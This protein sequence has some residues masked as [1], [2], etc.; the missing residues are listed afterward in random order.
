MLLSQAYVLLAVGQGHVG[1]IYDYGLTGF[2]AKVE[3]QTLP[4]AGSEHVQIDTHVGMKK[5]LL[6]IRAFSAGR[7]AYK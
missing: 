5:M 3:Q 1:I 7:N 6:V 2:K 4:V